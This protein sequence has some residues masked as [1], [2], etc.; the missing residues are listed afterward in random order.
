MSVGVVRVGTAPLVPPPHDD[1]SI[2][3]VTGVC[4]SGGGPGKGAGPEKGAGPGW[5]APPTSRNPGR[6][7]RGGGPG[8]EPP[9]GSMTPGRRDSRDIATGSPGFHNTS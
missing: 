9:L 6:G 1:M 4:R 8:K 3:G 5:G 2:E 7:R